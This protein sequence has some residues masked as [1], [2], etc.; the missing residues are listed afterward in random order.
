MIKEVLKS[1]DAFLEDKAYCALEQLK[2]RD[3]RAD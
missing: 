1:D 3:I 2:K